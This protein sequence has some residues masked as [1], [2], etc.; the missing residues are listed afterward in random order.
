[1]PPIAA[2][3]SPEANQGC[4]DP[5]SDGD[6]VVDR[7]DNC[8][9][10]PGPP[11]NAGCPNRQLVRI[12]SGKLEMLDT[13]Y[14]QLDK[15]IIEQRSY[16]LLDNVAAVLGAHPKLVVQVEGHTDSRGDAA[17]N[18]DLSQRR[19]Q[20]VVDYLVA[21]GLARAQLQARGF[22]ATRPIADNATDDGRSH[23]RRVAFTITGGEQIQQRPDDPAKQP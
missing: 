6:T 3:C 8:P 13:V 4:P 21:K 2:R 20:A 5:D 9:I 19:A 12:V 10:E 18:M 11:D 16:A 7:L 15:A 17:H 14:F 22:G 1:M 23:N